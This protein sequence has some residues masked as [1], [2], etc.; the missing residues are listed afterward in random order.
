MP[1]LPWESDPGTTAVRGEMRALGFREIGRFQCSA[2]CPE[3]LIAAFFP[4]AHIYA[5]VFAP[6]EGRYPVELWCRLD[7]VTGIS[8]TNHP[9]LQPPL[10]VPPHG[11]LVHLPAAQVGALFQSVLEKAAGLDR[12]S[13]SSEA[14]VAAYGA[15]RNPADPLTG[16]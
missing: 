8:V 2:N 3:G 10:H 16:G 12:D 13:A 4:P 15:A 9:E 11:I 14:F 5:M 7:E 1:S 6:V